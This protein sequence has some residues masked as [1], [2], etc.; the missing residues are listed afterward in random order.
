[1][2]VLTS[3]SYAQQNDYTRGGR[4][5]GDDSTLYSN[6]R[7]T[8]FNPDDVKQPKTFGLNILIFNHFLTF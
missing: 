4:R 7:K 3:E 1:M 5:M 2:S 6:N 8:L